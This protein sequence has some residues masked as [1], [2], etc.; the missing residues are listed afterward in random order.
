MG[1]ALG[2]RGEARAELHAGRR[3]SRDS[4]RSPRRG[5]CPPATNTG[6]RRTARQDL[7]RQHAERRPGRYGRRPPMPSITSASAPGAQQLLRQHQRR[8]R[9][10]ITWAPPSLIARDAPFPAGCRRPARRG[11]RRASQ[12]D[13]DQLDQ[14]RMHGDQVDAER[15]VG[16][17]LGRRRSRLAAGRASSSRRRSRRSRRRC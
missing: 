1:D 17:R 5:R 16:Q 11:R 15:L 6:T 10:T 13:L 7:L 14:L 12:A 4:R 3:P 2:R 8:A 9:S